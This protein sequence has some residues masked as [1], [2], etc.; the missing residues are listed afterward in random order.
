MYS[1]WADLG[2]VPGCPVFST[3][4]QRFFTLKVETSRRFSKGTKQLNAHT[5]THY[6]CLTWTQWEPGFEDFLFVFQG[7]ALLT[8]LEGNVFVLTTQ[9]SSAWKQ[10]S[11][12]GAKWTASWKAA[13]SNG[14]RIVNADN[15]Q[16]FRNESRASAAE[17][18]LL[19]LKVQP[20]YINWD[21]IWETLH[22]FQVLQSFFNFQCCFIL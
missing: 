18:L 2:Q 16:H 6:V 11:H 9:R 8:L 3:R 1:Q 10:W 19:K 15:S 22:D 13:I 21:I 17:S 12:S 14:C 20:C 7:C 4:P 5:D